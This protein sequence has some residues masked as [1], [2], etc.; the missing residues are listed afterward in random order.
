MNKYKD[1]FLSLNPQ[2]NEILKI[3]CIG[4]NHCYPWRTYW[5]T[6]VSGLLV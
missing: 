1:Y 4:K 5:R 3:G 2:D 6:H